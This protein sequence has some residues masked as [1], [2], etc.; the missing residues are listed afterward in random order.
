MPGVRRGV[1]WWNLSSFPIWFISGRKVHILFPVNLCWRV[2]FI[3]KY[4]M[5]LKQLLIKRIT[6]NRNNNGTTVFLQSPRFLCRCPNVTQKF[7][8]FQISW[9]P[10]GSKFWIQNLTLS[11]REI[12]QTLFV[13]AVW[14]R[15]FFCI[16]YHQIWFRFRFS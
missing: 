5:S 15:T 1:L 12:L 4:Q 11:W 16:F 7:L 3:T 14:T 2:Y 6:D 9:S 8:K 13:L 10:L